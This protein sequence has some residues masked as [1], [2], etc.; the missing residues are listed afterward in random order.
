MA[1]ILDKRPSDLSGATAAAESS[2]LSKY[3]LISESNS[4]SISAYFLF[5]PD[6]YPKIKLPKHPEYN[7][8]HIRLEKLNLN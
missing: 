3:S 2:L 8:R 1:S 6:P 5:Y 7:E 4:R